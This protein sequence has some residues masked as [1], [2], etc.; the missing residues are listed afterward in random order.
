MSMNLQ[1]LNLQKDLVKTRVVFI[2]AFFC[3][4]IFY[5][6]MVRLS[7]E[8]L[9]F[10]PGRIFLALVSLAGFFV[11]FRA[12]NN[13]FWTRFFVNV[14]S[15]SYFIV[16]IY[17]AHINGWTV[18]YR[19]SYAVTVAILCA[20]VIRWKDFLFLSTFAMIAA[21]ISAYFSPMSGLE[22][23]H[24]H[25]AN[26]T[27]FLVIGFNLHSNFK[28]QNEVSLLSQ[29]LIESSKMSAL[30]RMA[31]GV[32][33]EVNSPLQ[34]IQLSL[35]MIEKTLS[36]KELTP[37]AIETMRDQAR[38]AAATVDRITSIIRGLLIFSR[39]SPTDIKTYVS[40]EKI[41]QHTRNLCS[42]KLRKNNIDL[43][44]ASADGIEIKTQ[45]SQ[46]IQVLIN[47]IN[48]AVDAV[49]NQSKKEIQVK[50]KNVSPDLI[51]ICVIDSGP[52]VPSEVLPHLM[53]PF[54]TTK[55]VGQGTG[56]GLSI[57]RGIIESHGGKLFYD[58]QSTQ[59]TFVIELPC[60]T[61][62]RQ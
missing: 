10:V 36:G 58:T 17:L 37:Q 56:L 28:Y 24:F 26:L 40:L 44:F 25:A 45:E 39:N 11:T 55:P 38:R 19:W 8:G 47:L 54:F 61:I 52:G 60:R 1:E 29:N 22:Q 30:G 48:N 12:G 18:F 57:S 7:P 6:F 34:I 51:R 62:S 31:G 50:V 42:E 14:V 15:V 4:Y 33:H 21:I 9:D 13:I 2:A 35:E 3:S 16:Y 5:Y 20:V 41:F 27:M 49:A 59:S 32:A 23:I 43:Q 46:I 53:E